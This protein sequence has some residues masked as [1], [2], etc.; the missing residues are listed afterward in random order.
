MSK[1]G[2]FISYSRTDGEAFANALRA[3]LGT[4]APDLPVWQDRPEI[5][6]GV[7]WWRQIEEALQRVEF[8]VIVMTPGVLESEVTRR[9]WRA[10]RQSG[11]AVFPVKGPGFEPDAA[12]VPRWMAK[13]HCYDLDAQWETFIAHLRR[14][15]QRVRVPFMAPPLPADFVARKHELEQLKRHFLQGEHGDPVAAA[16]AL[17]GPGGFGKT[18][19]AAAL[20]HDDDILT[21]FDDGVLWATLGQ[22]AAVQGEL[23]RLYA[24]LTGERPSFVSVE[25][26]AQALGEK[27]AER[28]CLMVVDDVWHLEDLK[29]FVRAGAGCAWLSTTRQAVVALE[30]DSVNVDEMTSDEAVALLIARLPESAESSL[31]PFRRLAHRLGEWPLLLKLA[32]GAM[33]QRIQRGDSVSGALEHVGKALDRRGITAFDRDDAA[34]RHGAVAS[35]VDL[36]LEQLSKENRERCIRL[37]AFPEDVS[38]P[39]AVVAELWALDEFD[40]E[41][42]LS[43][44][45]NASLVEF[46]LKVGEVGMHD[47]MRAYFRQLLGDGTA[48][49]HAGLLDAWGDVH[50]L[51]HAYAW[52]WIAYHLSGAGR[53]AQIAALLSNLAWLRGKVSACGIYAALDDFRFVADD[54]SLA[55]VAK[56]LRLSAH[57]LA[58]DPA[59]LVSQLLARMSDA[60]RVFGPSVAAARQS[61]KTYL[62][63]LVAS[64]SGPDGALVRTLDT[65]PGMSVIDVALSPSGTRIYA[66]TQKGAVLAWDLDN[67]AEVDVPPSLTRSVEGDREPDA[68]SVALTE[69][70][71][72]RW[73]E[74]ITL[75][76]DY[77]RSLA[78]IPDGRLVVGTSSG[79]SVFTPET[80]GNLPASVAVR[81]GVYSMAVSEN[82]HVLVGTRKGGLS[83]WDLERG[84]QLMALHG[85]RVAVA[86]VAITADGRLGLSGGYDKTARLWDLATGEML[87]TLHT[88]NE[89]VV[90]SV[91]VAKNGEVAITG[92]ADGV[93]RVWDLPDGTLRSA[94]RSHTHRIYSLALSS[95]CRY[96]LSASHD[97]TVKLWDL[98]LGELRRTFLGHAG[99]VNSV[100]FARDES[101]IAS[102]ASDGTVRVWQLDAEDSPAPTLRHSGWIHAVALAAD[103]L[104][105]V[106]AGQDR[107]VR[108][109]DA[110]SGR[111]IREL[112]GHQGPVTAVAFDAR[113]GRVVSGSHDG[114]LRIWRLDDD[115]SEELAGPG[116]PISVVA[117][118]RDNTHALCGSSDGTV[119]LWD[120]EHRRLERRWDAHPRGITFV[121]ANSSGTMAVT[122]STDGLLKT[123]QLPT[124]SL[125][126]SMHAH[127]DG[128][129]A[130][131]MSSDSRYLVTGGGDG[132]LRLWSL[133]ETK[134]LQTIEAHSARTRSVQILETAG[135]V[136]TA[137]YDRYVRVWRFPDLSPIAGF[138]ADSAVAAVDA[139]D[140]G[141]MLVAGDAQG[142]VHF[143]RLERASLEPCD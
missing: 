86:S 117:L 71:L 136:V 133:A 3:R 19:L 20:C 51:P 13:V 1:S 103:G 25:D 129:T 128:I 63:P 56:A 107:V 122:G 85:H 77:V 57:A 62:R 35:T 23:T 58:R 94:L 33:R 108:A 125:M 90:Y 60:D 27:L 79:L 113:L 104:L 48:L 140:D 132:S 76:P 116:D 44:L 142:A 102:G 139:S 134:L 72:V 50:A 74:Q 138:A 8:L 112:K 99:S 81:E 16:V 4:E 14:G 124:C 137:G 21:A 106:T 130:G 75:D 26:A 98:T 80:S 92:A 9:E 118:F 42:A 31:V 97:R 126:R 143:L 47:V 18:T 65:P 111:M 45:D 73:H 38:I 40:T 2:V 82:G 15:A 119:L 64:L 78:F 66:S 39:V 70:P 121:A 55:R 53:D 32:A 7:G 37:A 135:L 5:Q 69:L 10:A 91:A 52:R 123:W 68:G 127:A 141:S 46:D 109:W 120:L 61:A 67:G 110:A 59:Q 34:G 29:P 6:G 115:G 54:P 11:V 84:E 87:E 83:V 101:R 95:D 22:Q 96:V 28:S 105:A 12:T 30:A 49:V 88:A 17:A 43:K 131:A 41:E 114:S 89:G 100:A 24:A 36:G 93:V